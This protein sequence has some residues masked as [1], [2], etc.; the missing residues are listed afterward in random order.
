[1]NTFCTVVVAL[2]YHCILF[3]FEFRAVSNWLCDP[4]ARPV[5]MSQTAS[6]FSPVLLLE[7]FTSFLG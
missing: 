3:Y 4:P 5:T 6:H 2:Y 7:R 1:M